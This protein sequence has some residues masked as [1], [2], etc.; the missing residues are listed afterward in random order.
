MSFSWNDGTVQRH[1]SG[2]LDY[3]TMLEK[4]SILLTN[5]NWNEINGLFAVYL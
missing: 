4:L 3:A 2:K 1:E 5:Y